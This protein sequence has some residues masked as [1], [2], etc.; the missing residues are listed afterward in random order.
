MISQ[1]RACGALSGRFGGE[2]KAMK[3]GR[4][5][6]THTHIHT[7]IDTPIELAIQPD[8]LPTHTHTNPSRHR[9]V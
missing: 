9:V 5:L 3:E 6:N 2:N 7:Y 8:I 1:S 4:T